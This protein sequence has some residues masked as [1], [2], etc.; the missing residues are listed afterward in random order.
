MAS[1]VFDS[2]F[3][4]DLFNPK[5]HGE[6]RAALDFLISDLSKARTRILIPA[7]LSDRVADSSG[8]RKGQ[9]FGE[10]CQYQRI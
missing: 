10:A 7:P 9:V 1:V 2:T 5:L 8:F 6:K 4:I 3:L